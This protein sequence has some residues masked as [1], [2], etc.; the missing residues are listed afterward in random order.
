MRVVQ[1]WALST[2][3]YTRNAAARAGVDWKG[4]CS[5]ASVESV[6]VPHQI[7]KCN[8]CQIFPAS[9]TDRE[10]GS[11]AAFYYRCA[12]RASATIV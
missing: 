10:I 4:L 6:V 9:R 2:G 1:H 8:E 11:S 3:G 7:H 5:D 12:A